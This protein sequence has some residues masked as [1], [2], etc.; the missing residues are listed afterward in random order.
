MTPRQV[1]R[2]LDHAQA[3]RALELIELSTAASVPHMEPQARRDQIAAW[4][5]RVDPTVRA[6]GGRGRVRQ[7]HLDSFFR[8]LPGFRHGG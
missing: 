3:V 4:T 6:T 8:N 7:E 2:Y 5:N 1:R